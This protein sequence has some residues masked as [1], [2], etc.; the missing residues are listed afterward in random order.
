MA[1]APDGQLEV[2]WDNARLLVVPSSIAGELKDLSSQILH[3]GS[4]VDGG[5]ST[6]PLSVVALPEQEECYK[7][8][9]NRRIKLT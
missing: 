3:N 4:H 2:P 1:I 9:T 6:H 5:S 7:D 8:N